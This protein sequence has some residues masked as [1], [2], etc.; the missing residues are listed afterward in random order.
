MFIY[1]EFESDLQEAL[2][3]LFDPDYHPPERFCAAI[4]CY[5]DDG[6]GRVRESIMKSIEQMR[7]CPGTPPTAYIWQAY[8][9][10]HYRYIQKLTQEETA[11][12]LDLSR[13]TI[14][15][16]QQK[17][18]YK[19]AGALQEETRRR[20]NSA[21][22]L[23]GQKENS[24]EASSGSTQ[25]AGWEEQLQR[26][27]DSL[28]TKAP[29]ASADVHEVIE[30][31]LEITAALSSTL[32]IHLRVI[33][34]Q[35]DLTAA[36][37]P[38]L[39]LQALV[40]ILKRLALYAR[41]G[42]IAIYAKNEDGRAKITL[43]ATNLGGDFSI[44][45]LTGSISLVD[46]LTIEVLR[47]GVQITVWVSMPAVGTITV[48]V[49]DDNEDMVRFYRDCTIG[50]RYQIVHVSQGELLLETA[51]RVCPDIIV[52]D[53]MLP[54]SDGWRLLMH[55]HADPQLG[56]I[57]IIISSVVREEELALSLGAASYLAKPVRPRQFIQALNL[58]CGADATGETR[59][60]AH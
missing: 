8:G 30:R 3:R 60:R 48:L 32:G 29:N 59:G 49:V 47:E 6:D 46:A 50:T 43:T 45:D 51:R 11:D 57:P 22:V 19:L 37:H 2:A 54:D 21:M 25:A 26:E 7:P 34:V 20:Q 18:I 28:Q 44:E 35:P 17:A 13:R 16:L 14:N 9:L 55:L 36:V 58:I 52:L 4:G 5:P 41:G 24:S 1:D 31:V 42:D 23:A 56:Q 38:V 53:V 10:L 33:S 40:S 15:R 27:V 39:L 12:R